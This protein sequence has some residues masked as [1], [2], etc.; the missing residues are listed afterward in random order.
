M[1][2][3]VAAAGDL[4]ANEWNVWYLVLGVVIGLLG[5]GF[6]VAFQEYADDRR[7]VEE[8]ARRAAREA[9][10]DAMGRKKPTDRYSWERE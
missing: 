1:M 9:Y 8:A 10:E 6:M 4:S 2:W 3:V 5:A 7:E